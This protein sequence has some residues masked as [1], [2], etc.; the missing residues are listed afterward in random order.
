[1]HAQR[2][3]RGNGIN[4]IQDIQF[5][6]WEPDQTQI[7]KWTTEGAVKSST[8]FLLS[9]LRRQARVRC[10]GYDSILKSAQVISVKQGG[11]ADEYICLI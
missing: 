10:R 3:R 1:M 7:I 8:A 2:V 4:G 6:R 5:P 9:I 11:T